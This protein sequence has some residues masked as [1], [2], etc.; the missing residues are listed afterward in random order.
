MILVRIWAMIGAWWETVNL[1]ISGM[2]GMQTLHP[3]HLG[4]AATKKAPHFV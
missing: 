1:P 4:L 3:Q 2:F